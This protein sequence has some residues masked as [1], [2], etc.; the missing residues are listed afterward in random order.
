MWAA[1]TPST[2]MP[3]WT[4]N[5]QIKNY[6]FSLILLYFYQFLTNLVK[7]KKY[8]FYQFLF[9]SINLNQFS[10]HHPILSNP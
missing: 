7:N 9:I 4:Y 5:P 8:Q 6:Q 10:I 2:W 1:R 3:Y